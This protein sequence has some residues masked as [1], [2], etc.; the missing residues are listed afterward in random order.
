M[1]ER[2]RKIL[3]FFLGIILPLI[4]VGVGLLPN[5]GNIVITII[6]LTWFGFAILLMSPPKD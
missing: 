3:Y 2:S 6:G 5:Y 1:E 4:L